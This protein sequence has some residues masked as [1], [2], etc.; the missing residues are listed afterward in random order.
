MSEYNAD[1]VLKSFNEI[2]NIP[3]YVTK[4]NDDITTIN[5]T[6]TISATRDFVAD[7]GSGDARLILKS[8]NTIDLDA[9]WNINIGTDS[10]GSQITIGHGTGGIVTLRGTVNIDTY[11][12]RSK[13]QTLD[14]LVEFGSSNTGTFP[15]GPD[16]GFYGQYGPLTLGV[17]IYT[18]L[19][20]DTSDP[21]GTCN[22]Y[23]LSFIHNSSFL[24]AI[25]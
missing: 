21:S 8:A 12:A 10:S 19:V 2:T 9:S 7:G 15:S 5:N 18:G 1:E 24:S 25:I 14:P 6:L 17:G 23:L 11:V 16:I 13:L 4:A 20:R 22:L 3:D